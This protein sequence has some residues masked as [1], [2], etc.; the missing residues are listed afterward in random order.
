M[1]NRIVEGLLAAPESQLDPSMKPLIEKWA[2]DPTPIQVLEVL[3]HCVHGAL[4]SGFV[5]QVLEIL[6]RDALKREG[7]TYEMVVEKATWRNSMK[8][9]V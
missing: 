2:D 9:P 5:I 7:I 3:D 4:A 8:P 6:L 1:K